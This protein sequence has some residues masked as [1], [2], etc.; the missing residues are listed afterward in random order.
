MFITVLNEDIFMGLN[1]T[2]WLPQIVNNLP[3]NYATICCCSRQF[4]IV[5]FICLAFFRAPL[6][7]VGLF[8]RWRSYSIRLRVLIAKC[9]SQCQHLSSVRPCVRPS[10][11][12][13]LCASCLQWLCLLWALM[14]HTH[15]HTQRGTRVS[16]CVCVCV[17]PSVTS[18]TFRSGKTIEKYK[19]WQQKATWIAL[20]T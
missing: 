18:G 13:C 17:A 12:P 19:Q 1:G 3:W 5:C 20:Y 10:V 4:S 7:G 9:L 16:V 2:W 8:F 11:G 14:A 6:A 15:T